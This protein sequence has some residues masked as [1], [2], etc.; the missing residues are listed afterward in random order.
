MMRYKGAV[1]STIA[2]AARK[3]RK[4]INRVLTCPNKLEL[5]KCRFRTEDFYLRCVIKTRNIEKEL[6]YREF[7]CTMK[8]FIIVA[9][10]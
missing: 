7:L 2:N 8:N 10:I 6:R 3:A 9:F 4:G 5:Q 1:C